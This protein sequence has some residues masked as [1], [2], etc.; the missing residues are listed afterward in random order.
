MLE[1]SCS[2]VLDRTTSQLNSFKRQQMTVSHK[3]A[4]V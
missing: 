1:D 2:K 4:A 3:Q